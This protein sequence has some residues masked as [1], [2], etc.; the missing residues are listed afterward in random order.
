[1]KKETKYYQICFPKLL[2]LRIEALHHFDLNG[3]KILNKT[4]K[5]LNTGN[6]SEVKNKCVFYSLF[7][8]RKKYRKPLVY[9]DNFYTDFVGIGTP[10]LYISLIVIYNENFYMIMID[11]SNLEP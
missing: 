2:H 6:K 10:V 5:I 1:M 3:L 8:T 11:C 7:L 9:S 4:M